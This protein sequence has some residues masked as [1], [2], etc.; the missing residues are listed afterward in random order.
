MQPSLPPRYASC[1]L[2]GWS[3]WARWAQTAPSPPP[4]P[5][6]RCALEGVPGAAATGLS[7]SC[8]MLLPVPA[9]C[10]PVQ[11][12]CSACTTP[13]S[14]PHRPARRPW[15]ACLAPINALPCVHT[16]RHL[17]CQLSTRPHLMPRRPSLATGTT[18]WPTCRASR[19]SAGQRRGTR[20]AAGCAPTTCSR[21]TCCRPK[22]RSRPSPRAAA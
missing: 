16:I 17:A 18:C 15:H 10:R 21:A 19:T 20:P 5:A 2:R 12:Q 14:T 3:C 22:A 9:A 6:T 7:P 13:C 11:Q 4:W 8:R 1:S